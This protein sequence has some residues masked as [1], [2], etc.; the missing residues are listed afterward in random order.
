MKR[1]YNSGMAMNAIRLLRKALPGVKFT[2]D[3]IVGFPGESEE[4]FLETVAFVKEARFLQVHIFPYSK[5]K[6]TPAAAMSGQ[7]SK[8]EKSRRLHIL[9]E[10]TA[11]I[12]REILEETVQ[13]TPCTE[14]LFESMDGDYATG[15]TADFIE[16]AVPSTH[17]MQAELHT[18]RLT[19]T[20]GL[21]C[22]GELI[23]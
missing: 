20:D 19:H 16:V 23:D 21:R 12:R 10:E 1:K 14:V 6:G 5:R 3:V 2:T 11:R 7:I 22:Y 9:S 15:H 8:E 18:V 4:D 17:S 13:S